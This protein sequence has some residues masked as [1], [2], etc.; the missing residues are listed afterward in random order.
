MR[1]PNKTE[2]SLSVGDII[3][4]LTSE[5]KQ[6]QLVLGQSSHSARCS[7]L[8]KIAER[9]RTSREQI[10]D[11]NQQDLSNANDKQLAASVIDR[12]TLNA[13]RIEAMAIASILS[14]LSVN[15]SITEAASCL[16]FALDKSC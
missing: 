8:K 2:N 1:L 6:A 15:L 12:L 4:R 9:I 3:E 11:A 13:D 10:M 16:S 7:A 5:A 14:A